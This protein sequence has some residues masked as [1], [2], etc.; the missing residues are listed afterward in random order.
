MKT[1]YSNAKPQSGTSHC[2]GKD[3]NHFA[4]NPA[5]P[6]IKFG[7]NSILAQIR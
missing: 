7:F 2:I 5:I 4:L 3:P 1:K 6:G